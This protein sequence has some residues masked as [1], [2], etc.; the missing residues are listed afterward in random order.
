MLCACVL[1]CFSCDLLIVTLWT[2]ACQPP[3]SMGFSRQK[4]WSGLPCL[5]PG[6]LPDPKI[7]LES[8]V[9]PVLAGRFFT[10]EPPRKS[11][12]DMRMIKSKDSAHQ[13]VKACLPQTTPFSAPCVPN[14]PE[15][16]SQLQPGSQ[17]PNTHSFTHRGSFWSG[18][19]YHPP[20]DL[21]NPGTEPASPAASLLQVDTLPLSHQ[22]NPNKC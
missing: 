18:L 17:V 19:A 22:G 2:V 6:D 15:I 5:P 4:Y 21:S 8:P 16:P 11:P 14:H 7:K 3:L 1:S 12:I 20:G 13:K 10:I 9:S